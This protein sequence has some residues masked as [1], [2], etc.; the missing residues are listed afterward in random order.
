MHYILIL[1]SHSST[2]Y[3]FSLLSLISR[4]PIFFLFLE[5]N[6]HLRDNNE[7]KY[8]KIEQISQKGERPRSQKIKEADLD[9]RP[10]HLQTQE[11]YKNKKKQMLYA[12]VCANL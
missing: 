9:A 8:S 1:I 6:R 11:S 5:N 2:L 12:Y 3:S 10:T 4:I 7:I